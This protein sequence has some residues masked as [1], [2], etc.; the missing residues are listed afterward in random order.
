MRRLPL[1]LA[2]LL[3]GGCQSGLEDP[4]P[5]PALDEAFFRCRAQPVLVKN[6]AAFACHGDARRYLR[7]FARNRLRLAGQEPERNALLRDEE[8]AS[9]FAAARA[10]VDPDAP[11]ESLLLLK[12]LDQAIGGYYHGGATL[13]GKGDVFTS[14]DDPDYKVLLSWVQGA[15]ED[16]ACVEPG[17]DQ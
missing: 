5:L 7:L 2:I 10:F 15:K 14:K 9:N 1:P 16:P 6:C 4:R 11:E 12:P 13:F 17:S 8:R 3:L